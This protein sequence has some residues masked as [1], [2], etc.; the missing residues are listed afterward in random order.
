MVVQ[1]MIKNAIVLV[2]FPFDDF[3]Y[4]KVRPAL[5]LTSEIGKFNHVIIAFISNRIP[6][7]LTE[8]DLIIEKSSKNSLNTG[9][10]VDSVIR[11]H[12]MLTIPKSLIIRK[13]GE[14]NPS[15]INEVSRNIKLLF[16][17]D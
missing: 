4:T 17:V 7:D 8:S 15:V 14:I 10:K 9:L 12:K 5:C 3:S 13:L 1:S 6:D 2:P 16:S 11:L